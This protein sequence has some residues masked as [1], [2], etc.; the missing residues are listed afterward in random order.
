MVFPIH[1]LFDLLAY[2]IGF[3]IFSKERKGSP[4][5]LSPSQRQL[6][7]IGAAFGG[8]LGSTFLGAIEH[9]S[10]FWNPPSPW[11]YF[12]SK[13]VVGGLIGGLI[14]VELMKYTLKE[15]RSTGDAFVFPLLFGTA[16]G[17]VGC[18]LSGVS[19]MTVGLPSQLPWA[20]E[21]GD[22]IL[23]HPTALYEILFLIMLFFPLR[24]FRDTLRLPSGI[25]FK[26]Y[27]FCYLSFRVGVDFLKPREILA[28]GLSPIQCACLLALVFYA[29]RHGRK[30]SSPFS[31]REN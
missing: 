20:L 11:Y 16:I 31:F 8:F 21:Q 2:S 26:Y 19:D 7:I 29:L 1:L 14:G 28:L 27:L 30:L 10:L 25:L 22:G 13:S 6:V 23:R 4:D 18:F 15:T 12:S 9:I 24:Y 3:W 17:R 5:F